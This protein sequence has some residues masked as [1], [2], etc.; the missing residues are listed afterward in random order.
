[1][2]KCFKC[3][4]V[5]PLKD[6]YKHK[7]MAD[8]HLN[9][10]KVCTKRDSTA[11]RNNNLSKIRAYDRK[12]GARQTPEY[13]AQ[14]RK[15]NPQKYKA[16][17]MVNNAVR[18]GKLFSQPCEVCEASGTHAHHDDYAKPLNVRWL[19]PSCHTKWH[20]DNGEGLNG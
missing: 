9:K 5:K 12:R 3:E 17:T 16:R 19:C 7:Q 8:G 4:T 10:C 15:D 2:K 11:H 6:F 18:D 20:K 14:Y 13:H 1:M